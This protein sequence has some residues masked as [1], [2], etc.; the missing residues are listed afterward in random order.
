LQNKAE[1]EDPS[2]AAP[3][4]FTF[5]LPEIDRPGGVNLGK[6]LAVDI[7]HDGDLDSLPASLVAQ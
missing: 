2:P 5:R 4:G 6:T 3:S 7:D 1:A